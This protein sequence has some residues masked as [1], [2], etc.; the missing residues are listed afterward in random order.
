PGPAPP[1]GAAPFP[2]ADFSGIPGTAGASEAPLRFGP[3]PGELRVDTAYHFSF[4]HPSDNTIG[5]SSE[6]FR[7]NEFQL[8]QL[9][10]GGDFYYKGVMARLMTQLGMYAQTTPR[11]DASPGRGQWDLNT[12]YRYVSEAYGGYPI[13]VAS[14]INIPARIF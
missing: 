7:H 9:G 1:A 4:N 12:A 2:S 10:I 3:F 6:V 5:G 14:G 11:N 13:H 8:I